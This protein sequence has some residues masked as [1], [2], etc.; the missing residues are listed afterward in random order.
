M[1]EQPRA[2]R[3]C[4]Q[5]AGNDSATAERDEAAGGGVTATEK[6]IAGTYLAILLTITAYR[7]EDYADPITLWLNAAV[8]SPNKARPSYSLAVAYRDAGQF[9][10][11][12]QQYIRVLD[13]GNDEYEKAA[14]TDLAALDI[15]EGRDMDGARLISAMRQPSQMDLS[16][17]AV[18]LL[19][20]DMAKEAVRLLSATKDM[21]PGT[22]EILAEAY[23]LTGDCG[24][25]QPL[26]DDAAQWGLPKVECK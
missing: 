10:K 25:A 22:K 20:N 21:T 24:H 12:R 6:L 23:R 15:A 5:R 17:L 2:D 14:L 1:A 4:V 3:E 11:A 16:N 26:Y 18:V 9:A 7:N 8:Q 19:R 13:L